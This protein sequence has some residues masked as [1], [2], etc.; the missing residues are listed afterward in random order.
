MHKKHL[1]RGKT[2][3]RHDVKCNLLWSCVSKDNFILSVELAPLHGIR[4]FDPR[5]LEYK[6][7]IVIPILSS[8]TKMRE[9]TK[10]KRNY[11]ISCSHVM[12]TRNPKRQDSS[13]FFRASLRNC[14][15]SGLSYVFLKQSLIF[16]FREL[17]KYVMREFYIL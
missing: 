8:V 17:R 14:Y 7:V 3:A 5:A 12:R 9:Y 16:E 15:I 11:L 13:I 4:A 2:I 10:F 1:P 6:I